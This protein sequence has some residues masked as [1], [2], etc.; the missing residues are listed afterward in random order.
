MEQLVTYEYPIIAI[1]EQR[2]PAM[3]NKSFPYNELADD[4]RF[5]ELLY[6]LFK[7]KIKNGSFQGFDGISLMSGVRDK[8]RDCSL[9]RN[10][11]NH[12]LIQCKKYGSNIGKG[13][14][15]EEITK[16]VMYTLLEGKLIEDPDD[17]TY[18][19]AVS[20]GFVLDCTDFID[21]FNNKMANEPQ[22]T[23]W[24]DKNLRNPTLATLKL[25]NIE[26]QVRDIL[27]R[28][29]VE[30]ILPQDLDGYLSEP[31]CQHLQPL[32]FELRVLIDNHAVEQIRV[33]LS[34]LRTGEMKKEQLDQELDR[35]SSSLKHENN[36]FEDIPD[37]HIQRSETDELLEWLEQPAQK[38]DNGKEQN[39][40]LLAGNAGTGKTVILKDFYDQLAL[41]NLPILALKADKLYATSIM[42]LQQKIGLTLP[43]FQFI[44]QCK[45]KYKQTI[46]VIDQ[47]DAL[48]Q[49][50]SADRSF[51]EVYKSLI[52][53]YTH[54]PNVRII[55]SVRLFDLYY[56][57]SL[58]VYKN[59][60]TIVVSPLTESQIFSL[61]EKIGIKK[62]QVTQKLLQLLKV[63]N[64]LN[65]FARISPGS[66]G[67]LGITNIQGLYGELWRQKVM[68]KPRSLAMDPKRIKQLCYKLVKQMFQS[69]RISLSEK[70]YEEYDAEISYLASE[71]I[72]KREDGQ[73]QFFH[74]SFYD[75]VFAKRFV[76]KGEDLIAYLKKQEQSLLIRSALKMILNYLRDYDQHKYEQIMGTLLEDGEVHY[77]IKHMLVS[78]LAFLEHPT[79]EEKEM[80]QRILKVCLHLSSHF[81]D[82]ARSQEWFEMVIDRQLISFLEFGKEIDDK[83]F[84]DLP[85]D[86]EK[87]T[88]KLGY[89]KR[90]AGMLLGR[91][92]N[93]KNPR[94]WAFLA[95][96]GNAALIKELLYGFEDWSFDPAYQLLEKSGDFF[97][98][99]Q[100]G[101]MHILEKIAAHRPE[102]SWSKI[103]GPLVQSARNDK[104]SHNEYEEVELLKALSKSIPEKMIGTLEA[105]IIEDLPETNFLDRPLIGD[106]NYTYIDLKESDDLMGRE[107]LYRLLAVCLRRAAR[108]G[109]EE[110]YSFQSRHHRSKHKAMLRLVI[111]AMGT[112]EALFANE[113]FGL[114]SYMRGIGALVLGQDF[115]VEFRQLFSSTFPHFS[116]G[117]KAE[118]ASTL[119]TLVNKEEIYSYKEEGVSKVH[120]NWGKG[121][122]TFLL[123]LPADFVNMDLELK[124][125]L[126]ELE[127]K[128][129]PY[130]D[131]SKT[132]PVLAG[133]V[134]RPLPPGAYEKMSIEQWLRSFR[135][136]SSDRDPFGGDFLKGGIEEHSNAFRDTA[137]K[138]DAEK[139]FNLVEQSMQ[140]AKINFIYPLKGLWGLVDAGAEV[141]RAVGITKKLITDTRL[142]GSERYILYFI[143]PLVS[144]EETEIELIDFLVAQS[145]NYQDQREDQEDVSGE[146]QIG[147]LVTRGINT[148]HGSAAKL[149][150]SIQDPKFEE[151][152]FSALERL[153]NK[154]PEETRAALYFR[155]AY[156]NH[157]NRHRAYALFRSSLLKETNIYVTASAIWSLQYMGNVD[158]SGLRGVYE[159]LVISDTLGNDDT[160]WLV[161][162]LY[163]SHLFDKPGADELLYQL[164]DHNPKSRTWALSEGCKHYHFNEQ[165]AAKTHPL[166][167]YLVEK[168]ANDPADPMEIRFFNIEHIKL[169]EIHDFLE[170]FINSVSFTFSGNLLK[171]LT[172]QCSSNPQ[173][174]IGLFNKAIQKRSSKNDNRGHVREKDGYTK[175]IVGAFTALNGKDNASR[176]LRKQLLESFDEILRDYRYRTDTDKVLEELL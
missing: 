8:G 116:P 101:Y 28:I 46:L 119:K 92:I 77:H 158:F 31:G 65:I 168:F 49:A 57:P 151:Q 69:Q 6:A 173:M 32:F 91:F 18:Y 114:F 175:F 172:Q 74:Q 41:K 117:Q 123:R 78:M 149:L 35:G 3:A 40:C 152:V 111:F 16:F 14:F 2:P 52:D 142:A 12:G 58:R 79:E 66:T 56:D 21:D 150:L 105:I 140:D 51:L 11:K 37:S 20:Q 144:G 127:R 104:N 121:K 126:Q 19:I 76:E 156:L 153:L 33:E 87:A 27:T 124:R 102:Y 146:T 73:L 42:E 125:Q 129:G 167:I 138:A 67:S 93:A 171:Y 81:F 1:A 122:Y 47:I 10:G 174:S 165:S 72:L 108:M 130:Q 60:K 43:V 128:F 30:K 64:Q 98:E 112:N 75:F 154:A 22:L 59:I 164:L 143:K 38:D 15:G 9:T 159:K 45:Q 63:P 134:R 39:I 155:F 147:G 36:Q 23:T 169:G 84:L 68:S 161:S 55:I 160:N 145:E 109:A 131:K 29:K 4:R 110:F 62:E 166:L 34:E 141:Q 133:V 106:H 162:I 132:G 44:E 88:W 135:R 120:S 94:A 118:A 83:V 113:V 61:L 100:F 99:D 137:G 103:Q 25:D 17:F 90:T 157:L 176:I 89:F 5:E 85:D 82:Q 53:R 96:S 24:I 95:R 13:I 170:A 48:S 107:Y 7:D 115:R 139:M 86:P 70:P 71:R 50:M 26:P 163:F 136:Y 54:D 80:V 97:V 148:T